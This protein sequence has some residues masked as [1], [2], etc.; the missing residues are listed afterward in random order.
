MLIHPNQ[1]LL[2]FHRYNETVLS[3]Y[4]NDSQKLQI[5][6]STRRL[7]EQLILAHRGA[8]SLST[9]I[10]ER[11][12]KI[13][14]GDLRLNWNGRGYR[15]ILDVMI[16]KI[17]DSSKELPFYEKLLLNKEVK[18]VAW[19]GN[20]GNVSVTC[21][22]GSVYTAAHVIFTPS[23][24]VLKHEH[25]TL[26]NPELPEEKQKAIENIALDAIVDYSLYFP[27]RWW[28]LDDF[29]GYYFV[30]DEED[31]NNI[32]KETVSIH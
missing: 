10:V 12:Y 13:C 25:K 26:F 4:Q 31:A 21:S 14:E 3:R 20:E 30:W 15:T 17:P 11:D 19:N 23:V 8:F 9:T 24:G 28:P 7:L 18:Q 22:D 1:L 5:A 29:S 16:R 32:L 2:F 6:L 27:E